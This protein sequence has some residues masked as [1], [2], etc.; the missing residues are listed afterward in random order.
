M[1]VTPADQKRMYGLLH[2]LVRLRDG[3]RC[4]RCANPFDLQLSHIFPKGKHPKMEWDPWNV[5]LLCQHCHMDW[6]HKFPKKG[7]AWIRPLIP[8]REWE[9]LSFKA[10]SVQYGPFKAKEHIRFLIQEITQLKTYGQNHH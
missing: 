4:R 9:A 5:K 3:E 6:W 7:M 2:E 10:R 8:I 1:I